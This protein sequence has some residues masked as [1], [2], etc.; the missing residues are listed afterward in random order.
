MLYNR[1]NYGDKMFPDLELGSSNVVLYSSGKV[2]YVPDGK[3]EAR[4]VT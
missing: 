3:V 4:F 2:L 1:N